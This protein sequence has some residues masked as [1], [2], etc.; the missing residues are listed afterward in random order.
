MTITANLAYAYPQLILAIG[1]LVLLV[2]GAFA[3]KQ[4]T[5]VAGGGVL[6]L[7]AAAV[8]AATKPLGAAFGGAL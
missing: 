4:T 3:P 5:L 2:L 8:A 7:A 1:A 6:V